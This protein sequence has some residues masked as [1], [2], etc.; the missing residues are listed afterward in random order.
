MMNI[1]KISIYVEIYFAIKDK[2]D[3]ESVFVYIWDWV[4][5]KNLMM[6]IN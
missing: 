4:C 5:Y 3:V 2:V 6:M 1:K